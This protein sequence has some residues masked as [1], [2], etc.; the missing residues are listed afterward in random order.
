MS[1]KNSSNQMNTHG[2]KL[3]VPEELK[4]CTREERQLIHK[5]KQLQENMVKEQKKLAQEGKKKKATVR[6]AAHKDKQ[7]LD[8]KKNYSLCPDLDMAMSLPQSSE[9]SVASILRE[10]SMAVPIKVPSGEPATTGPSSS[11]SKS[12]IA[13]QSPTPS[14][15]ASPHFDM[16]PCLDSDTAENI[17][18]TVDGLEALRSASAS[19]THTSKSKQQEME[20]I[21]TYNDANSEASDA[22]DPSAH[23]SIHSDDNSDSDPSYAP[24]GG[25]SVSG[26]EPEPDI[27]EMPA[28]LQKVFAEFLK[29]QHKKV[30]LQDW[31]WSPRVR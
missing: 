22:S 30:N 15:I 13:D 24:K 17:D 25:E 16:V 14:P 19:V 27:P 28:K 29:T 1:T 20:D 26:S 12:D 8:N 5:A 9:Q 2:I 23:V 21:D 4:K 11:N 10:N 31:T 18:L 6:I 3:N 7:A